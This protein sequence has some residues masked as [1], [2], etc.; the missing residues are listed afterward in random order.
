MF[1]IVVGGGERGSGIWGQ[2]FIHITRPT[3]AILENNRTLGKK[4][5]DAIV[6][7]L[8]EAGIFVKDFTAEAS[9]YGSPSRRVR[10]YFVTTAIGAI[11][12]AQR[13]H[14]FIEPPFVQRFLRILKDQKIGHGLAK[15]IMMD[16]EDPG[17]MYTAEDSAVGFGFAGRRGPYTQP[18]GSDGPE[19]ALDLR[20]EGHCCSAKS[21][22]DRNSWIPS[23]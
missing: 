14:D 11:P 13:E 22:S 17:T 1:N 12:I 6:D 16:M 18:C 8:N 4:N 10:S 3:V 20:P 5:I 23:S 15:S 2:E 7:I 21:L 9:E 19:F